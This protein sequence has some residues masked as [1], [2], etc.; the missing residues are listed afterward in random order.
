MSDRAR[1]R[2]LYVLTPSE[3]DTSR[4]VTRVAASLAGGAGLVQYRAKDAPWALA[5]EQSLALRAL[6]DAHAATF[7]VNDSPRLAAE[8]GADGVHIGRD[9]G[10]VAAARAL[11]PSGIVGVSCYDQPARAHAAAAQGADYVA[12]GSVFASTT[13][14]HAPHVPLEALG[15]AR[16]A[17]VPVVAIGG[18]TA[19]NAA[20]AIAAG[21]DMVAVISAVFDA[22]DVRDAARRIAD[23]FHPRNIA[24]HVR[25]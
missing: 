5:L 12:I 9:D 19:E 17:G 21:A 22:P 4:L 8:V 6:C 2:G 14:P 10:G 24:S 7:I 18:I 23:C 25:T 16:A 20:A 11:L 1:L 15:Q 13:K 3:P